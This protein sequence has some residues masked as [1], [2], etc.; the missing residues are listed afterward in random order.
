M[1]IL[2]GG[3]GRACWRGGVLGLGLGLLLV[4]AVV[5]VVLFL[6]EGELA[7]VVL[8]GGFGVGGSG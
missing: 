2:N 7:V 1:V 6:H 8:E 5:V 3:D 4:E